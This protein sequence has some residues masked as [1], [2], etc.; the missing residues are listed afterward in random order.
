M[1]QMMRF[2]ETNNQ[3]AVTDPSVKLQPTIDIITENLNSVE[4]WKFY[5]FLKA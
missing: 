4:L 1:P 5:Q 3:E 2:L